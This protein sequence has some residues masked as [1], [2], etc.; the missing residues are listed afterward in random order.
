[1]NV[2][3]LDTT[4]SGLNVNNN[5]YASPYI[6]TNKPSSRVQYT[7]ILEPCNN[8]SSTLESPHL[9]MMKWRVMTFYPTECWDDRGALLLHEFLDLVFEKL[10]ITLKWLLPVIAPSNIEG[11]WQWLVVPVFA[12]LDSR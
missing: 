2:H 11:T 1:M 12:S 5:Y 8:L 9:R 4:H 7:P 3:L 6:F 10:R